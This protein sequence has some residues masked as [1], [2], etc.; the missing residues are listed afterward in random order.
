MKNEK[1]YE[2]RNSELGSMVSFRYIRKKRT[3]I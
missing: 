3:K 1:K 2:R